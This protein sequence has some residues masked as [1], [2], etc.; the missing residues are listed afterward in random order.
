MEEPRLTPSEQR[1]L[2]T[3]GPT[4]AGD[5]QLAM[6]LRVGATSEAGLRGR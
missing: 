2:Q 4:T 5:V 1:V 3:D 6:K